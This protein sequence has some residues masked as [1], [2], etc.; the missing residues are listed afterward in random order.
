MKAKVTVDL[1]KLKLSTL[2]DSFE[3]EN[4]D[5]GRKDI[6]EFLIDDALN[7]QKQKLANLTNFRKTLA[8]VFCR[9]DDIFVRLQESFSINSRWQKHNHIFLKKDNLQYKKSFIPC[10]VWPQN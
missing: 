4:F 6:N 2:D 5:C 9:K 3:L 7:Y 10:F 1:S 8:K